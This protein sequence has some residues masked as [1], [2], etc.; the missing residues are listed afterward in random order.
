MPRSIEAVLEAHDNL[1][2]NVVL[3]VSVYQHT[4]LMHIDNDAMPETET[5]DPMS[6]KM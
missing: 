5:D 3:F 6:Q 2:R 1:P 4:L